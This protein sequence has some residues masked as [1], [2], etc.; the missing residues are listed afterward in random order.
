MHKL[1]K[2]QRIIIR[3]P[4]KGSKIVIMNT[5]GY[6]RHVQPNFENVVTYKRID[7]NITK[8]VNK[9]CKNILDN[10]V[11]WGKRTTNVP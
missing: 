9:K 10:L 5:V 11:N 7:K 3:P 1:F 4:N 8:E 6:V 2:D